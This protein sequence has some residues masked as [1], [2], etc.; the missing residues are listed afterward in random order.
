MAMLL[1]GKDVT[2]ALNE[3][4]RKRVDELHT[5]Y[6]FP[7]LATIRVGDRG[8]DV[9]YEKGIVSRCEK[10]GIKVRRYILPLRVTQDEILQLI[11]ELNAD[12]LISGILLF[13]PLPKTFDEAALCQR[14]APQKDVDCASD[15]S[16]SAL[17]LGKDTGF[18]PCTPA[19]CMKI[20][21]HYQIDCTAKRAVVLGRS[22]VVGKP[23]AMLLL[24]KNATVTICHSKTEQLAALCREADILLAAAGKAKLVTAEFIKP[25][26]IV[27]DV[28]IHYD[29]ASGAICGDVDLDS[30]APIAGAVTPVPGGVGT[31]TTSV[32]AEH[33][34]DAAERNAK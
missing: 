17:F 12:A 26:A 23:A 5:R 8:D 18:A 33:V 25:G 28:G 20:L 29:A 3:K 11:D 30:V 15:A 10:L 7:V 27:L 14:I 34:I 2:A 24:D 32:L 22:L 19:A 31:V 1:S 16:L 4:L 13:R 6:I 9:S 21:E